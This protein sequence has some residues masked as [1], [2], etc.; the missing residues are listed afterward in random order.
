MADPLLVIDGVRDAVYVSG[1]PRLVLRQRGAVGFSC[2]LS[3]AAGMPAGLLRRGVRVFYKASWRPGSGVACRLVAVEDPGSHGLV[4]VD[5]F[6]ANMLWPRVSRYMLG[7]DGLWMAERMINGVRV[8]FVG[9]VE[10]T[11]EVVLV[12]V[13]ST[14]AARGRAALFPSSPGW[15]VVRQVEAMYRASVEAGVR[16]MLVFT[17]LR[18]DVDVLLLDGR[19][20]RR[21]VSRICLLVD[22]GFEVYAYRVKPVARQSSIHVFFDGSIPVKCT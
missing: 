18:S 15:R 5:P 16:A 11:G 8:D 7:A 22:E 2:R 1:F 14:S 12:E 20:D 6:L 17:V 19:V 9:V 3:N 4:L 21:L 13:K 10:D